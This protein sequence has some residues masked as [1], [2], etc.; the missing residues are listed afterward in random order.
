MRRSVPARTPSPPNAASSDPIA[1]T[2]VSFGTQDL[3]GT[4]SSGFP[5]SAKYWPATTPAIRFTVV[6]SSR[7]TP[8]VRNG[9]I[10]RSR[11]ELG[12]SAAS[13]PE[14]DAS[15]TVVTLEPPLSPMTP[16]A[17]RMTPVSPTLLS[18]ERVAVSA[19]PFTG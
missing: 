12:M 14:P 1:A 15:D 18:V 13:D 19:R 16:P 4:T 11:E 6:A 8:V 5:V 9:V 3:G 2:P 10:S 7:G 17:A